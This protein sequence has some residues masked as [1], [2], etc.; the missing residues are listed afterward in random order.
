LLKGFS[1]YMKKISVLLICAV[2]LS[3]CSMTLDQFLGRPATSTPAPTF[4]NTPTDMPT[5]TP[6][7]PTPTFTVTPTLAGQKKK[8]STPNAS[9]TLLIFTPLSVTSLPSTTPVVLVTQVK[10]PGFFSISVSDEA[11]YKGTEC[12][13]LS[14]KFTA[15]V[16]DPVNVAFVLLFVRFK[17]KQTGTTSEWTSITMQNVGVGTFSHE[18]IPS[19]M[20]AV[21]SFENAW[22]QYQLVA[23]DTNSN[24]IGR[25]DVFSERLTLFECVPTPTPAASITP[26]VLVP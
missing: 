8:T 22:V 13:P 25:T 24:P 26:T 5:F 21:N 6:T 4:T 11:F 9:P 3:A 12:L 15:Q 7:V 23:T 18:L 20:K 17:S 16:A 2:L 14:V 1:F 19:E 10:M